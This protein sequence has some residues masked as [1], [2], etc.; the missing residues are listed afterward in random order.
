MQQI[1]KNTEH[2]NLIKK[3][4]DGKD[5]KDKNDEDDPQPV[6][7]ED[8]LDRLQKICKNTV[9]DVIINNLK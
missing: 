8:K 5:E 3:R 2:L 6:T 7:T 1:K 4:R 9:W